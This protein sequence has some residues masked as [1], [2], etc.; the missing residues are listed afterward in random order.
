MAMLADESLQDHPLRDLLARVWDLMR[1][2]VARLERITDISDRYQLNALNSN[3]DLTRRYNR[4]LRLLERVIRISDRY[5]ES[6][7]ALNDAL[8]E[9]STHDQLTGLAN[10]RLM[11]ER[12][13]R[14]DSRVNRSGGT[15]SLLVIDADHF[16]SINDQYGHDAGDQILITLAGVLSKGLREGDLCARWGGEEFLILLGD[17]EEATALR[18][19]ER[20]LQSVRQM[21]L[22]LDA[23]ELGLTVSLGL[24]QH[25]LGESYVDTFQ[26]ADRALLQAKQTGRDRCAVLS[27]PGGSDRSHV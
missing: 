26:R 4:Q 12:C 1:L 3:L 9:A 5:Q 24:S 25:R 16:K 6:L 17:A 21:R 22:R 8:Q 11:A 2:Q 20:I 23:A 19:A 14:E 10:R 7:K 15:Y 27:E 13:R 18:V